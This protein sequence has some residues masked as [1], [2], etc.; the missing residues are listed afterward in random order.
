M[1]SPYS[2]V[3]EAESLEPTCSAGDPSATSSGTTTASACLPHG[4]QTDLSP[5]PRSLA[6]CV[7]SYSPVPLSNTEDLRT[8]LQ[9]AFPASRSPSLESKKEPTTN[10]TCGQQHGTLFAW[11]DRLASCWKTSQDSFLADTQ[12]SSSVTWP[13]WGMWDGGAAYQQPI[14]A[15]ITNASDGGLW[16]TPR[17]NDAEKRGEIANDPRNG[18]PAAV[19][20]WPTPAARDYR[21]QHAKDSEAFQARQDHT[22]G[23]N[24]VEEMQRRGE[25]GQLNPVWVEWLMGWPIGWTELKP[26][27]TGK[28]R[29]FVSQ[30]GT[31]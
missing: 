25:I 28:F 24:L 3:P 8:W 29:E 14:P 11:F 2:L 13:R 17:A 22:R 26:L 20:Y 15:R 5:P 7:S 6:T 10:A 9:R 23:V 1:N 19:K 4:S 12:Q 21:G 31:Y 30:H 16:P 27:E 18:L